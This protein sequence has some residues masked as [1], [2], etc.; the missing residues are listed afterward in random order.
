MERLVAEET[1]I[2][3]IKNLCRC[4]QCG[5]ESFENVY[6]A[7]QCHNGTYCKRCTQNCFI[8]V[9]KRH[10]IPFLSQ[11]LKN[12]KLRCMF[13]ESGCKAIIPFEIIAS[14]E[15]SC[16]FSKQKWSMMSMPLKKEPAIAKEKYD[17]RGG[18][19]NKMSNDIF[20]NIDFVNRS[21]AGMPGEDD[22]MNRSKC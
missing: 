13:S 18:L 10:P 17:F 21:D 20:P 19:V 9:N 22:Y 7:E 11:L 1:T 16:S 12:T 8:C 15:A 3:Q 2:K 5:V 14:H 6:L 4:K